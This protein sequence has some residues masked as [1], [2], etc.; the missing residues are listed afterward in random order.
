MKKTNNS[1]TYSVLLTPAEEGGF[2]VTVPMLPGCITEGDTLEEALDNAREVISL[3]IEDMLA[4]G[5][6]LPKE[7]APMVTNT[8]TIFNK[9]IIGT[10]Q[11]LCSK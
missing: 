1:H 8:I 10:T 3:Y 4:N 6:D 5:E 11:I 7:F 2:T 9:P